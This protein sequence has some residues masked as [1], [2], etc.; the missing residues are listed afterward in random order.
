LLDELFVVDLSAIAG[1]RAYIS[2]SSVESCHATDIS[3]E[4]QLD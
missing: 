2:M 4:S 1:A 3:S